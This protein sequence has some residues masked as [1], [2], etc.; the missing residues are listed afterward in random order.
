MKKDPEEED[1]DLWVLFLCGRCGCHYLR[2]ERECPTHGEIGE[3]GM[4]SSPIGLEC[5]A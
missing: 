1:E 4:P 3:D 5:R 2:E